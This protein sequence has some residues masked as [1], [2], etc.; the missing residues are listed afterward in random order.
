LQNRCL[1]VLNLVSC[2]S[3]LSIH[4]ILGPF[5]VLFIAYKVYFLS[6]LRRKLLFR[7]QAAQCFQCSYPFCHQDALAFIRLMTSMCGLL[8]RFAVF[9]RRKSRK[10]LFGR[11]DDCIV[12]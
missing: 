11:I 6:C 12:S 10:V 4:K 9:A 3:G 1:C 8:W 2:H 7:S 5:L